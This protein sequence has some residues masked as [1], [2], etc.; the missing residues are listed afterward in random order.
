MFR[1]AVHSRD[2]EKQSLEAIHATELE[3]PRLLLTSED[4]VVLREGEVH[5]HIVGM[6]AGFAPLEL[7][8]HQDRHSIGDLCALVASERGIPV[9]QQNVFDSA[10]LAMPH[11]LSVAELASGSTLTL[12]R[13]KYGRSG[14]A[15]AAT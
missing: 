9:E 8:A 13:K 6:D 7:L 11:N 12:K 5:I 2:F 14:N 10:G 3:G 1:Q 15:T 4:F